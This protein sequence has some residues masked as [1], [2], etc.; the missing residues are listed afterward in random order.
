MHR[1]GVERL[2]VHH[3]IHRFQLV[4]RALAVEVNYPRRRHLNLIGR[5]NLIKHRHVVVLVLNSRPTFA[6]FAEL[7]L[8]DSSREWSHLLL[9]LAGA[10]F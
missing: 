6:V 9:G 3:L 2:V 8:G 7:L 5:T 4:W 1:D 10:A